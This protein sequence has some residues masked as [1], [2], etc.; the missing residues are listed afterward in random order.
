MHRIIR[1]TALLLA[2]AAPALGAQETKKPAEAHDQHAQHAQH[3]QHGAPKL[4]AELAE[5]FKGIELSEEQ[6]RKVT[7][8][9]A[10]HHKAMDALKK[11]AK[12]PNDAALK[13][14]LQKHMDAEHAEF[15]A[16]LTAEQK[17]VFM[18]N[19]KAHH[20]AETAGGS[21]KP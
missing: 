19:M 10:K 4:D 16:L 14:A 3:A 2:I 11:E 17:K 6:V 5:H 13:A 18:E 1:R 12:D 21:K 9:K 8:I 15:E 20:K 7:E